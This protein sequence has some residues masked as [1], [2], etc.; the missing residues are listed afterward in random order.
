MILSGHI[1]LAIQATVYVGMFS[2][3]MLHWVV[4]YSNGKFV[5][6]I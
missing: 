5:V 1:W 2:F 6:T 4:G 3:I